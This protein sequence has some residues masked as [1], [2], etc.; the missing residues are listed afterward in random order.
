[1]GC[2]SARASARSQT[3]CSAATPPKRRT[4]RQ[5]ESDR[6]RGA[7]RVAAPDMIIDQTRHADLSERELAEQAAVLHSEVSELGG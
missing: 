5:L 4:A 3:D 7:L 1:M 6:C 2:A